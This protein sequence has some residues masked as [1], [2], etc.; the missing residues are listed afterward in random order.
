MYSFLALRTLMMICQNMIFCLGNHWV[1][2]VFK[3]KFFI[4]LEKF[5]ITSSFPTTFHVKLEELKFPFGHFFMN[6]CYLSSTDN[7]I[8]IYLK[9]LVSLSPYPVTSYPPLSEI[10]TSVNMLFSSRVLSFLWC[11][12]GD[13]R[14]RT[15]DEWSL[16]Q[17]KRLRLS[18]STRRRKKMDRGYRWR[19]TSR[20]YR[21]DI[22]EL[23]SIIV[24]F[25]WKL[26][27]C[28]NW[29]HIWR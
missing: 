5:S 10:F 4:N 6:I 16:A 9:P 24:D 11:R 7:K 13:R 29:E 26:E 17:N 19:L 14:S 25:Y 3:V 28:F 15:R 27:A 8:L 18:K 22:S 23:C 21:R 1:F 20:S 2:S 12:R